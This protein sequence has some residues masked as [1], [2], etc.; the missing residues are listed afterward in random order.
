M[1]IALLQGAFF[2]VPPILGGAVEKMWFSL[3]KEFAKQGHQVTQISRHVAGLP[4]SEM[5]E[6][7][8]HV[9]ISGYE[10]PKS[11]IVL[12]Y[13]DL[14]YTIKARKVFASEYDIIITNTFW[15][16]VLLP[17]KAQRAVIVDVQRM[18][19][20]QMKLYGKVARLRANS[21][22]VVKAIQEEIPHSWHDKVTMIP[23]PLPFI[24]LQDVDT[25]QKKPIILYVGRIHPEKGL[26]LLIR[27]CE[28]TS[29]DYVLKL[30]GP[31]EIN[32]GGGGVAYVNTLKQMAGKTPVEFVG[33]VFDMD[34]LNSYYS[35]ASI[36]VYPSV[37]EKGETF[38][39]APLEAMAW[40]CVTI[41]SDLDCFKDFIRHGENGLVFDHRAPDAAEQL[42]GQI[43]RIQRDGVYRAKLGN[44]ALHVRRTHSVQHIA[45]LF[46]QEFER[47]S[48]SSSNGI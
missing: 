29:P 21:T 39:L 30:V 10:T 3:G 42:A 47:I 23:N 12:K 14:L 45:D 41:V 5:I 44:R 33:P 34:Q 6:G 43:S 26:D 13:F 15:A 28:H 22:A 35:A 24:P 25:S 36:F 18:P 2:P 1:R 20:R 32:A 9:R 31:W 8:S 17:A 40:G 38:G 46:L 7:V 11:G 19:K 16:P 37:A 27:A 4:W 48:T